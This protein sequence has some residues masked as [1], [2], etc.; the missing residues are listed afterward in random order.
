MD[1]YI[2]DVESS[3]PGSFD[4]AVASSLEKLWSV[5]SDLVSSSRQEA[6]TLLI[7]TIS[8]ID[9][10]NSKSKLE[11]FA[12]LLKDAGRDALE[13]LMRLMCEQQGGRVARYL[14][15]HHPNVY[16]SFFLGGST[17]RILSWFSGMP[18]S[19]LQDFSPGAK[20]LC[21]FALREREKGVWSK[22]VWTGKHAQAPA[23]VAAKTHYFQELDI[24]ASVNSILRDKRFSEEFLKSDLWLESVNASILEIDLGFFVKELSRQASLQSRDLASQLM[25]GRGGE[26]LGGLIISCLTEPSDWS[27]VCQRLLHHLPDGEILGLL[28]SSSSS[29]PS[30]SSLPDLLLKSRLPMNDTLTLNLLTCKHRD[31]GRMILSTSFST[32]DKIDR[33]VRLIH[34]PVHSSS[35]RRLL[36]ATKSSL[37]EGKKLIDGSLLH[38]LVI[39]ALEAWSL[40]RFLKDMPNEDLTRAA[41]SCGLIAEEVRRES[42][43][44]DLLES[45]DEGS[46]KKKRRKRMREKEKEEKQEVREGV[47]GSQNPASD[48]LW[49]VEGHL[50]LNREDLIERIVSLACRKWLS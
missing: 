13:A 50:L 36:Q 12:S 31:F 33:M 47:I 34:D 28:A 49:R 22:L 2:G 37:S 29:D 23:V 44:Y 9:T 21:R 19:G 16:Q 15:L 5:L 38:P 14:A 20:A 24:V 10:W 30:P 41:S 7:S 35:H 48:A 17:H 3:V 4:Q 39:I 26:D 43:G 40:M 32:Q 27:L 1:L 8:S 42:L 46:K 18:I 6:R 25:S 45:D 11:A